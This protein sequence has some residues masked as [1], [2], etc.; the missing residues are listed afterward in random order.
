M[1]HDCP[2]CKC[3]QQPP[4]YPVECQKCHVLY[5]PGGEVANH[6]EGSENCRDRRFRRIKNAQKAG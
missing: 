1:K 4:D 5:G 6:R 2:S 3:D